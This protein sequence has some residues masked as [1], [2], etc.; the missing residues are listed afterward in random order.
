MELI[1][2]CGQCPANI[3]RGT[4][5]ASHALNV[6]LIIISEVSMPNAWVEN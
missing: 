6:D 1:N 4:V 3:N 5:Q 2:I